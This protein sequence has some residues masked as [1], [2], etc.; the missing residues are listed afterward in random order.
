[1]HFNLSYMMAV[2]LQSTALATYAS[3]NTTTVTRPTGTPSPSSPIFVSPVPHECPAD[4]LLSKCTYSCA[5]VDIHGGNNYYCS[6]KD[7]TGNYEYHAGSTT[8]CIRCSLQGPT[9]TRPAVTG[10]KGTG[11][12]SIVASSTNQPPTTQTLTT[13]TTVTTCPITLTHS[14]G[15]SVSIETTLTTS[16]VV[17]TSCKGGC[18]QTV[19]PS[20][21]PSATTAT[22][23]GTTTVE[24]VVTSFVPCSTLAATLNGKSYYSTFLTPTYITVPTVIT[25]TGYEVL[26]P[27]ETPI[28]TYSASTVHGPAAGSCAPATTIY[29]TIV[30]TV[31]AQAHGG[32]GPQTKEWTLSPSSS[33]VP[34]VP[35]GTAPSVYWGRGRPTGWPRKL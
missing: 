34:I 21:V 2:L 8:K 19:H 5:W 11:A 17:V 29:S 22:R 15:S 1:M 6:T 23:I 24:T 14:S 28:P 30:V 33:S 25:T 26:Y 16:T 12:S 4:P 7:N 13:Y 3:T 10:P 18:V 35:S 27:G 9:G 32:A 20:S 31:T